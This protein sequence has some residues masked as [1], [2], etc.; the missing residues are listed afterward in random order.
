MLKRSFLLLAL[1]VWFCGL[2]V[3]S[4]AS[5]QDT[6]GEGAGA[7][8]CWDYAAFLNIEAATSIEECSELET[9]ILESDGL[10]DE[11]FLINLTVRYSERSAIHQ[12]SSAVLSARFGELADAA[13]HLDI[14]GRI[15]YAAMLDRGDLNRAIVS[16][17]FLGSALSDTI[18]RLCL[19]EENRGVCASDFR[20]LAASEMIGEGYGYLDTVD[21]WVVLLCQ[22]R[23]DA[24]TAHVL[25]VLLSRVF[26]QCLLT[27]DPTYSQP[28]LTPEQR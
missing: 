6:T 27:R 23:T 1:G 21:P 15:Y 24:L 13:L 2:L 4:E 7:H 8:A 5:A 18:E 16:N 28:A 9:Y 26:N 11:Q 3:T 17:V 20:T 19:P 14:G 10:S 25:E 12:L 22:L